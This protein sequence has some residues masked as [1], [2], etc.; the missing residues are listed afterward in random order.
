VTFDVVMFFL[1]FGAATSASAASTLI[2]FAM[3]GEINR[4]RDDHSQIPYF[5]FSWTY[6]FREYRLLYPKGVYARALVVSVCLVCALALISFYLLFG[7]LPKYSVPS[8]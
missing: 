5:C 2:L 4:K 6:V 8:R 7:V 1:F 3:V